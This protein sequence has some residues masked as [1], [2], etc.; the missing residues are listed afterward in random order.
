[1]LP[2][3]DPNQITNL[4]GARQVI[5][6]LLN[7]VEELKQENER[8]RSQV[9][10]LR[11]EINRLK[12]EQGK[13]DIKPDKP[14]KAASKHSSEQER[15]Q[16]KPHRKSSKVNKIAVNREEKLSVAPDQLP[17]DA[18]FKGYEAVVIQDIQ[19][20]TDNVRFLNVSFVQLAAKSLKIAKNKN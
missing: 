15:R 6:L 1:M 16:R 12:G 8:L 5:T 9:Q 4:D 7:L 2:G 3:F 18:Q 20:R 10:Q 11:D 13:P 17:A 19:L 14:A